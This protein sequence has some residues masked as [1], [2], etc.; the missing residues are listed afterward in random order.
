MRYSIGDSH[1]HPDHSVDAQGSVREFCLKAYEVGL[2][3]ITFTTHYE[4][5][6]SRTDG[7]DFFRFDGELVPANADAVKRYIDDVR[8][9]G[10]EFFPI[11]LQVK[12]GLE[13][14]WDIRLFDRLKRE[15]KEFELD[16]VVGSVHDI[17]DHPIL[18]RATSPDFFRT[19]PIEAW[20][21]QYFK[22][23]EEVADSQLFNVISHLDV[24]KRYGLA[25]YGESIKNAHRPFLPSLFEKMKKHSLALEVNTSG[26][27]H[28]VGEYYPSIEII[29]EARR[30][31]VAIGSLGSDAHHPEHVAYDFDAA[32]TFVYELLPCGLEEGDEAI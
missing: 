18:E 2:T 26:M 27:R 28:G 6:P 31:G 21:E 20:I 12:C 1:V 3:E 10:E 24:Y 22:K 13:V 32:M 17:D 5:L 8:R 19:R 4:V 30:A 15:L 9:V 25:V 11:G 16:C 7:M 14:G 29:N 23:A